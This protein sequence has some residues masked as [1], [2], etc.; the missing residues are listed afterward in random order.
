MLFHTQC[1]MTISFILLSLFFFIPLARHAKHSPTELYQCT[2]TVLLSNH[3]QS[4]NQFILIFQQTLKILQALL[5]QKLF[6][7]GCNPEEYSTRKNID[8]ATVIISRASQFY[9]CDVISI[10]CNRLSSPSKARFPYKK[11]TN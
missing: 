6:V 9:L 7:Q 5:E 10:S 2:C 1:T 3:N 8:R 4:T 11:Q